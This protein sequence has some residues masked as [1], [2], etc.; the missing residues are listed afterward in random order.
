MLLTKSKFLIGL[1]C[2][3]CFWKAMKETMRSEPSLQKDQFIKQEIQIGELAK[4]LFKNAID[5]G[6]KELES[7][8]K[9][10]EDCLFLNNVIFQ[11]GFKVDSLYSRIDI[12]VPNSDESYDIVE[13]KNST[14]VKDQHISDVAFQKC[15]CEKAGVSISQCYV[16]H[17]NGSYV[18]DGEI[19]L[20]ELFVKENITDKVEEFYPHIPQLIEELTNIYE[21]T[22]APEVNAN[23]YLLNEY[24][25]EFD[26]ECWSF[27]T[28]NNVSKLYKIKKNKVAELFRNNIFKISEIH[29]DM[30]SNNQLIQK[31]AIVN[32]EIYINREG[33][34]NFISKL[35]YPLYYLDFETFMEPIPRFEGSKVYMQIP[36]QFSLHVQYEDDRLEHYE[37]LHKD[38]TDPRKAI[39]LSMLDKLGDTGSIVVFNQVF[40]KCRLRELAELYPQYDS[41]IGRILERI[42]D[43]LEPFNKFNYYNPI[44]QGSCSIKKVLPAVT[45]RSY[46][47]MEIANGGDASTLYFKATFEDDFSKRDKEEVYSNLLEYCKLDTEGMVWIIKELKAMVSK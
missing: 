24:P 10:T 27:L 17:I 47:D 7:N 18:K 6:G 42:I 29:E 20:N 40:E 36:F 3:R 32:N 35:Q 9:A 23:K 22:Q 12:L 44:Q 4:R 25:C 2:P 19:N 46:E 31:K 41:C 11:A 37:F 28:K 16:L 45:G 38:K 43:L 8:I 13:V 15:V 21:L 5:L 26:S 39:L 14:K 30:L 33:I 1:K 34:K